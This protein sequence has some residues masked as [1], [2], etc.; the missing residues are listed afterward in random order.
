MSRDYETTVK[1]IDEMLGKINTEIT[2]REYKAEIKQ[3]DEML[4]NLK[5]KKKYHN[6]K[7]TK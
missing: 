6:R 2:N 3:I 1:E 5:N 7:K 4:K